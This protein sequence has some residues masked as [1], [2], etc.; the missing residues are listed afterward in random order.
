MVICEDLMIENMIIMGDSFCHVA[1]MAQFN[2]VVPCITCGSQKCIGGSPIFITRAIVINNTLDIWLEVQRLEE[3][4]RADIRRKEDPMVCGM[5]YLIAASL[6]LNIDVDIR[7]GINDS[8]FNSIMA[9]RIS[10]LFDV[11][12]TVEERTRNDKNMR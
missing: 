5:K 2:H 10:Q 7:T 1:R 6:C 9:H 12:I 4:T 8:R 11:R 3:E